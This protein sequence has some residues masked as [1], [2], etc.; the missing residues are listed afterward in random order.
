MKNEK[1]KWYF[2][3]AVALVVGAIIGY[4]ATS[5]LTTTGNAKGALIANNN[6]SVVDL[7]KSSTDDILYTAI[8]LKIREGGLDSVYDV[9]DSIKYSVDNENYSGENFYRGTAAGDCCKNTGNVWCCWNTP[10]AELEQIIKEGQ[11]K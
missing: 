2:L 1:M 5:N 8:Y 4:F 10:R 7:S 6:N 11:K 9:L 3:I